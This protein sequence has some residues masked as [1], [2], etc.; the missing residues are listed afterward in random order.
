ML[1]IWFAAR[2]LRVGPHGGT[3]S[4][5]AMISTLIMLYVERRLLVLGWVA[6]VG[7]E[8]THIRCFSYLKRGPYSSHHRRLITRHID[9]L[10]VLLPRTHYHGT[11][12]IRACPRGLH[13]RADIYIYVDIDP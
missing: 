5:I 6:A 7:V 13:A 3:R 4:Y 10:H 1:M 8:L 12:G 9:V 11:P 2:A